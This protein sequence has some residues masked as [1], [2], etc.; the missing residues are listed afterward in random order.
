MATTNLNLF[1]WNDVDLLPELQRLSL[2]L[3]YL[4][5][6][7]IVQ[8]LEEK[9]QGG[10]NDY[11]VAAMWRAVIAGIVFQHESMASLIRELSRNPRLLSVCGFDP[12]PRRQ[13]PLI[14]SH[15]N[16]S[17]FLL[18]LIELEEKRGL[19]SAMIPALTEQL[20]AALPDFGV[21]LG[22]DGKAI[23]SHSTGQKN[24]TTGDT[25][26]PDADWGKHET[27][28]VDSRTGK[29]W[30][31]VKSWF[32][33]ELHLIAD[34]HYEIPVAFEMTEASKGESPQLRAMIHQL[35][36]EESPRLG[37]R[38]R[39]FS[40][41]RGLDCA[42]TKKRLW[43]DYGIRPL[44]DTREL[45][46]EEKQAPDY[47]PS[48][49]ITRPLYPE[50]VDTIVYAE[51]G[52]V[53]CLCPHSG[54]RRDLAFQGFEADRNTLKY[55]CP[56]AA[57]G[58]ACEGQA[59]CHRLGGVQPGQY[60]RIVRIPIDQ[61]RRIF[62]PTPYGSPSWKKG[63]NRRSALERINNRI[64]HGY[65]FEKHFIRGRAKIKTRMGLALAVMMAMA[66][67]H[68]QAGREEQLRSL[69]RPIPIAA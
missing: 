55:R 3:D 36:R 51:K 52:T 20:M 39:D 57:Y 5:D 1:S 11:P 31:K 49:P 41:D 9:R 22:Y 35:L 8:A 16:F 23:Q 38:C 61:D 47:D 65:G 26:D 12:L 63:Y 44:I 32:G 69:V 40:A 62:T 13:G 67:G 27:V 17:R 33:Y 42:E 68:V 43:D 48:Q 45:W 7:A 54:E 56:A 2:V 30:K 14:P 59:T 34:T 64:D 10:R 46:R 60:G 15:H 4:P 25:S 19:V 24:R 58:L 21:H 53:H 50:R 18:N 28:G 29:P 66:L 6:E 37:E